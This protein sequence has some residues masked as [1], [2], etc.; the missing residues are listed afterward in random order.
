MYKKQ[1]TCYQFRQC[2]RIAQPILYAI[3]PFPIEIW[4]IS[5]CFAPKSVPQMRVVPRSWV[6]RDHQHGRARDLSALIHPWGCWGEAR[7]PFPTPGGVAPTPFHRSE[8]LKNL[9]KT[10]KNA[11]TPE[12]IRS[13]GRTL[14]W[15]VVVCRNPIV[16]RG[17]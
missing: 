12:I 1:T 9:S 5:Q 4:V 8:N 16:F 3:S 2:N 17:D 6:T 15:K 7:E 13:S 10:L 14:I 11:D